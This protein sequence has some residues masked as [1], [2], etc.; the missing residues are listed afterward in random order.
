[1][2]H[3]KKYEN[4]SQEDEITPIGISEPEGINGLVWIFSPLEEDMVEEW[5][6]DEKIKKFIE[7]QAGIKFARR[8]LMACVTGIEF[9]NKKLFQI[10]W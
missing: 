10:F 4:F 7:T 1:M 9:L 3:I 6:N 5:N 8:C 2:K